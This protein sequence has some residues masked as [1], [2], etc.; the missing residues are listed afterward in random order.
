MI[1][2]HTHTLA[3]DGTDTPRELM[4]AACK[5]GLSVIGLT[6][7]DTVAGWDEATKL[8]PETGVALVRGVEI[9]TN[10]EGISVHLLSYLHDP[11]HEGLESVFAAS[12]AFRDSRARVMVERISAD[13]ARLTWE[14]VEAQAS[15]GAPLGRPHIA[16]AL[17]QCGYITDRAE[18]FDHVLSPRG[19]Y[20]V[21]YET[22][23][24]AETVALVR[25]AGGVPVLAHVRASARGRLITDDAIA[26]LVAPGL[27]G[28]EVEH[29]DHTPAD[30][31]HLRELAAKLGVF[32]TGSSDYHGWG[33]PNLLG[34]NTTD[35]AVLAEIEAQGAMPVIRP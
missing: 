2:L 30:Q 22:P 26:S 3:S 18:A 1:D 27:A 10:H 19:P 21:R 16:D 29:R 11:A 12:R 7:H 17:V 14:Q 4:L 15:P 28:I 32:T 24:L 9:S 34:E 8:V 31:E 35:P 33:K 20:Y 6:D 5:A 13:Y 23:D 25:A